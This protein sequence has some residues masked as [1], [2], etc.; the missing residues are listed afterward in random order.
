MSRPPV[1]PSAKTTTACQQ[2]PEQWFDRRG[3]GE[4]LRQCL[5]CGVRPWCARQALNSKASWGLWAGVWI[6]GHHQDAAPYLEAIAAAGTAAPTDPDP[7]RNDDLT[8][9]QPPGGAPLVRSA[10]P[11]VSHSTKTTV[12]ARSSGNCEVFAEG[13]RYTFDRLVARCPGHDRT[14]NCS[15]T[16]VFA[17]CVVCA[18]TTAR[19]EPRLATRFG[20]RIDARRNPASVPFYWRAAR[21]V[22]LERDGWLTEI[23]SDARTAEGA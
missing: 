20:Y 2:N 13:C 6:D 3:R 22:L 5:V 16:A 7:P 23:H 15:P 10:A 8:V 12:L 19:M 11:I 17:A 9:H 4:A 21:W 1:S 14:E 18:D